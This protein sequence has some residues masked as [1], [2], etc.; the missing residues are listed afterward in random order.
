MFISSKRR[1][2]GSVPPVPIEVHRGL[3]CV[4]T[5][6]RMTGKDWEQEVPAYPVIRHNHVTTYAGSL[7]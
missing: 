3:N 5:A 6:L 4:G 2:F 1:S 7:D